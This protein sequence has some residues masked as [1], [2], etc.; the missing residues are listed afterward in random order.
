MKALIVNADDLGWSEGV[1]RGI[2]EAHR[3]GI[4]TSASLLANGMAFASA[5][6][7][8]RSEPRVG[9][10]VHLCLTDEPPVLRPADVPGLVDEHGVLNGK[11]AALVARHLRG[12]RRLAEVEREWNAQIRKVRETGI[13]PTHLDGH[14]HVH[15]LPGLF[16]IALWLAARH[17]IRAIR[18]SLEDPHLR[19]W[20]TPRNG[21]LSPTTAKQRMQA[22]VVRL[23]GGNARARAHRA[24]LGS[25]DFFC[26]ITQTGL[27][28][29]DGVMRLLKNLPEGVTELMA[30]PGYA[31]DEL[32]RS[33][34]RLQASRESELSILTAPEVRN[35]VANL[36]LRLVDYRSVA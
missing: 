35:L 31:D 20:L 17:G 21:W 12:G 16:E 2:A 27:L 33:P 5:V 3:S 15:M 9:V 23:L 28:T 10:G 19:A 1:N 29:A 11:P 26:G 30:H 25:P 34:T 32:R 4:V 24:G 18:V 36:G 7:L 13:E 8:A 6:E 14:K 22:D